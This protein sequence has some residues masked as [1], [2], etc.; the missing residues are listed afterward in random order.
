MDRWGKEK[1]N[2][3]GEEIVQHSTW[4]CQTRRGLMNQPYRLLQS[5]SIF[6][7]VIECKT[8]LDVSSGSKGATARVFALYTSS[9]IVCESQVAVSLAR[10]G[11][12]DLCSP[13]V[14]VPSRYFHIHKRD[15]VKSASQQVKTQLFTLQ[16]KTC[17][18]KRSVNH[19]AKLMMM[20][21]RPTNS[22]RELSKEEGELQS[23]FDFDINI[24]PHQRRTTSSVLII[25]SCGARKL[26]STSFT[27]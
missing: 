2:A 17:K 10:L 26:S 16:A 22:M 6:L 9:G 24:T 13:G 7:A 14:W 1:I 4:P 20:K 12:S 11:S 18:S 19:I 25:T 5:S 15:A 21:V 3:G 8:Q 23:D 27:R